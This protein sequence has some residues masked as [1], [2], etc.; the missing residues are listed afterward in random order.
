[1]L[2]WDAVIADVRHFTSARPLEKEIFLVLALSITDSFPASSLPQEER[3]RLLSDT[4]RGEPPTKP[5]YRLSRCLSRRA[6]CI[7]RGK[8]IEWNTYQSA[9]WLNPLMEGI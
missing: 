7:Q 6:K 5:P 2:T 9:S 4:K 8:R 1:M 3:G